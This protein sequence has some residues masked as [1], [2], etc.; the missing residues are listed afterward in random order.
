MGAFTF[1]GLNLRKLV[2]A[3]FDTT[4]GHDHDGTN[5]KAVTV[6]TVAAGA[7]AA[8]ATGRA[9]MAD[10]YFNAATLAAKVDADAMTNAFCDAAFAE[11]VLFQ[12]VLCGDDVVEHFFINGKFPDER[13]DERNILFHGTP[14]DQA[15]QSGCVA[16]SVPPFTAMN[17][18]KAEVRHRNLRQLYQKSV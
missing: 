6:G 3:A 1:K 8:N 7:L 14:D 17:G 2:E 18:F 12:S 4:S 10:D 5:S 11:Q 9:M 16:H 13:E 15:G